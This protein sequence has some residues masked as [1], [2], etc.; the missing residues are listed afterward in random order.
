MGEAEGNPRGAA[1]GAALHSGPTM[2]SPEVP[3]NCWGGG[4]PPPALASQVASR[5]RRIQAFSHR[6][7]ID[8]GGRG[9][10]GWEC[11]PGA[12][13]PSRVGMQNLGA[14]PPSGSALLCVL[15]SLDGE[16]ARSS[17]LLLQLLRPRT[18][19]AESPRAHRDGGSWAS[20]SPTIPL[21]PRVGD[22]GGTP[23]VSQILPSTQREQLQCGLHQFPPSSPGGEGTKPP[24]PPDDV[25]WRTPTQTHT[26]PPS[27]S[28][29]LPHPTRVPNSGRGPLLAGP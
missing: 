3:P 19:R 5:C 11:F 21:F 16:I 8:W 22:D 24:P 28:P 6:V 10:E 2:G 4:R 25:R 27:S 7:F 13:P 18:Q 14:S 9:G 12:L 20:P 17:A 26:L 29:H 23:P 15:R 1:V